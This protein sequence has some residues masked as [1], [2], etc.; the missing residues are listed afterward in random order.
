MTN[1][2]F[3]EGIQKNI[4]RV[5]EYKLGM[6]GSGGQCDCIGLIIGAVRLMGGEWKGTH[7]SNYAA[8]N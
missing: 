2:Q 3:L 7:G 4:A 8:R 5:R 6:D 1:E